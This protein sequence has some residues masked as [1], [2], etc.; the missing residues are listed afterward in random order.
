MTCR[1]LFALPRRKR[2]QRNAYA[3][4][5]SR[6]NSRVRSSR[7]Q[8]ISRRSMHVPN[9]LHRINCRYENEITKYKF[10]FDC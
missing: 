4:N 3:A 2:A 6:V 7:E 9:Q 10:Q 5:E 1:S 8:N